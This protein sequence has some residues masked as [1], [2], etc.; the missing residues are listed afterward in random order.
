MSDKMTEEQ[1]APGGLKGQLANLSPRELMLLKAMFGVFAVLGV[2]VIIGLAQRSVAQ[3]EAETALYEGALSLLATAGPEYAAAQSGDAGDPRVERFSDQDLDEGRV[4]LTS[5]VATHAA[6]TNISVSSYDEDQNP[7][8]SRQDSGG[9]VIT[10]RLLR[11]DIRDAQ[12]EP[13]IEMLHRIEESSEPVIIKRVD[14]RALRNEGQVR[15]RIFISTFQRRQQ[16]ES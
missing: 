1:D 14:I 5:F 15:A 8:G 2:A 7:L 3:L 6:A 11:V 4:Q 13:L 9:P 10:E 16:E 12:M